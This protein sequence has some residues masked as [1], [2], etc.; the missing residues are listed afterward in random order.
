MRVVHVVLVTHWR[1]WKWQECEGSPSLLESGCWGKDV[2]S[3]QVDLHKAGRGSCAN[4]DEPRADRE[5]VL[6]QFEVLGADSGE[7]FLS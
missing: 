4:T 2:V 5:Y 7:S 3:P 1:L 6:T